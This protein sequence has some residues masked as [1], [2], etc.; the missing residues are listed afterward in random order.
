MSIHTVP[1]NK[2]FHSFPVSNISIEIDDNW[3]FSIKTSK[4]R[5]GKMLLFARSLK[6]YK[7]F[8]TI[9]P[10]FLIA[11]QLHEIDIL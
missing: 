9:K 3:A 5:Q 7:I 10:N 8:V 11:S 2:T 6:Y 4:D 1:S